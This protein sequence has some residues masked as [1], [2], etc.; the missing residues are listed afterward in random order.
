M[1]VE[2]ATFIYGKFES[3]PKEYFAYYIKGDTTINGV[4]YTILNNQGLDL[5][6]NNLLSLNSNSVPIAYLR[7]NVSSKKVFAL[8]DDATQ[9]SLCFG[10][11]LE[12]FQESHLLGENENEYLL[13]DFSQNVGD[14]IESEIPASISD[15]VTTEMFGYEVRKFLLEGG[16]PFYEQ[17]GSG[18]GLFFPHHIFFVGGADVNL[19]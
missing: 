4:D 19:I 17:F 16:Q 7:E 2:G 1:V 5:N 18:K 12:A 10:L 15:I 11:S 9:F 3:G 6:N 8:I 14:D 13:Y